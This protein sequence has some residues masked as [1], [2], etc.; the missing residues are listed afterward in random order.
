MRPLV[1]QVPFVTS[2]PIWWLWLLVALG[3]L[4]AIVYLVSRI[5]PGGPWAGR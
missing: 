4:G 1:A 5:G 3:F 2:D